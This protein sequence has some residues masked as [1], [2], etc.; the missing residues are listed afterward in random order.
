LAGMVERRRR[1][2]Q[3]PAGAAHRTVA[4]LSTLPPGRSVLAGISQAECFPEIALRV[5]IRIVACDRR[6]RGIGIPCAV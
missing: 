6:R 1:I 3:I 2:F 4:V 5:A